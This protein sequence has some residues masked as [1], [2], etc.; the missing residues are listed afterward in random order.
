[1][2]YRIKRLLYPIKFLL[3]EREMVIQLLKNHGKLRK[4][5]VKKRYCNKCEQ[6]LCDRH[7]E[8]L[9]EIGGVERGA[10]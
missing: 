8:E 4:L 6:D 10:K 5:A 3:R 2:F 1:M 9:M 7:R